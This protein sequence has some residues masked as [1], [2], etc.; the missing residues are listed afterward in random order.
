MPKL[1]LITGD[2]AAGKTTFSRILSERYKENLFHKDTLK[3][4]LGE[5]IGFSNREE[6]LKL[7][8]AAI[9]LM[10]FIFSEFAKQNKNLILESNFHEIEL[11]RLHETANKHGYEVLTL[12]LRGDAE[13]LH[14]RYLNRITNENRHPVHLS[15]SLNDIDDFKKCLAWGRKEEIP[16]NT[17][18]INGNSFSC[19]SDQKLLDLI[20]HFMEYHSD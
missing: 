8:K 1:L 16:G 2:L 6:N 19:Q 12:V 18:Q 11:T 7:S 15:V 10:I 5:T 9:E 17:I 14:K 13:I 20:D 3:E 4:V